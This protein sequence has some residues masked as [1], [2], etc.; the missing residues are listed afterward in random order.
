MKQ[1]A[2]LLSF[3]LFNNLYSQANNGSAYDDGFNG[4]YTRDTSPNNVNADFSALKISGQAITIEAW[5]MPLFLDA[6]NESTSFISCGTTDQYLKEWTGYNLLLRRDEQQ[7]NGDVTFKISDCATVQNIGEISAANCL[8]AGEWVHIAVTFNGTKLKIY[9]NSV[10]TAES[11][12]NGLIGFRNSI[13][14]HVFNIHIN[15]GLIDDVRLWNV[16]RT[17]PEIAQNINNKLVG[18]EAGLAAYWPL[19]DATNN[20]TSDYTASH[21]DL[22]AYCKFVKTIPQT[23]LGTSSIISIDPSEKNFGATELNQYVTVSDFEIQNTGDA[24]LYGAISNNNEDLYIPPYGTRFFLDPQSIDKISFYIRPLKKGIIHSTIDFVKGNAQNLGISVPFIVEGVR[25]LGIDANNIDMWIHPNGV[26]AF[27][28]QFHESGLEWPKFSGKHVVYSSGVWV[29]AKVQDEIHTAVS[30]RSTYIEE[31]APGPIEDGQPADPDDPKFRVY[32]IHIN[33]NSS[34]PDYA[35][36]PVD[37]GAPVDNLRRPKHLADQTVFVVY[38]DLDEINHDHI[39][40]TPMG[41]EIQQTVFAWNE[42]GELGNTVFMR[43]KLINKSND[44]W[45]DTYF[46]LWS[47]PD[48]GSAYDDFVGIDTTRNMGFAYNGSNSDQAYGDGPPA[49]G[50]DILKG[51]YYTKPIQAFAYYDYTLPDEFGEPQSGREC[52]NYLQGLNR[53]GNP[54]HDP[55][56]SIDTVFPLNGD[57]KT[58]EGWIDKNQGDRRFLLSTGP[59]NLYPG[60]A[61]EI[62]AALIV[63]RDSADRSDDYL[64]SIT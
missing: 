5:V 41:A 18:N 32:K 16:E 19:D 27:N 46:A 13:N 58:N 57:P 63:A 47:D 10:L 62:V 56:N 6:V 24:P 54:Y 59:F 45:E 38:N 36:W 9:I 39:S 4:F 42:S 23:S 7:L 31:F 43:F 14:Q 60:Q 33:D 8:V 55:V 52:Y 53:Y 44:Y 29:G 48:V 22:T 20:I 40:S 15:N 21:N 25:E 30:A 35:E 51:A 26:F 34:N 61:K 49:I 17:Q 11:D 37:L 3:F 1:I 2:L 50:Y 28:Y 12:H 64:N